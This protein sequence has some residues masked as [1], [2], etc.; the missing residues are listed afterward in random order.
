[1]TDNFT[2][3][4]AFTLAEE[5]G[6]TLDPR[7]SGGA[8]NMGITLATLSHWRGTACTP[9]DVRELGAAE[10]TTIYRAL[11]WQAMNCAALPPGADLLVFDFGVNAGPARAAKML[12]A[13]LGVAADGVVGPMTALAA[14]GADLPGLIGDLCGRQE[15][16]YRALAAFPTFGA[17]WI[18]RLDRRQATAVDMASKPM[19][20]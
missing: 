7:D 19:V 6:F 17:G 18:A 9:A 3:C 2:R 12:Q 16:Y 20:S 5:G 1:M 4:V 13:E 10:A 15:I 8:T 11:Y 14:K